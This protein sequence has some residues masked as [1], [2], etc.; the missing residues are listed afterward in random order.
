MS[1][2]AARLRGLY[3]VTSQEIC[4]SPRTLIEAV[5]RALRGGARLVQ[6]RDKQSQPQQRHDN[7]RALLDS[8][9]AHGALLLINDDPALA[10]A[11]GADG[12]HLGQTDPAIG[13]ARATCGIDAVI[14]VS[15]GSS[16]ER[17]RDGVAAGADYVAFGRFFPSR[18][19]PE[20]PPAELSVLRL[21]RQ[22]L[23]VPICA[24]GGITPATAR[25]VVEAG[26]DLI[27][28][29]D[30]VFGAADIEAA[31]AAYASAFA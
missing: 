31:A 7:A 4:Q 20:A 2:T 12:V 26:A 27:A 10:A 8:C 5:E 24:I 17:A 28:A 23:S 18:T 11:V 29:V 30:G 3:A 16:L 25:S 1:R 15:C 21:A 6:Y 13:S 19:K 9:R 22:R 14:G